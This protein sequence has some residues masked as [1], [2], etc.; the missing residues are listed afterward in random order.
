MELIRDIDKSQLIDW[1]LRDGKGVPVNRAASALKALEEMLELCY[2][3]G[4]VTGQVDL[5]VDDA[6]RKAIERREANG[7]YDRIK[8]FDETGDVVSCLTMF[9]YYTKIVP[10]ETVPPTLEKIASRAWYPDE[11]GILRRPR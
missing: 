4:A 2:A 1:Q 3:A 9:W 6:R 11:Y 7:F 10:A 5:I 8:V